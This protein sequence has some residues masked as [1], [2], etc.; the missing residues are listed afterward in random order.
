MKLF[1]CSLVALCLASPFALA[2]DA[3]QRAQLNGAS[4][5]FADL[6]D[7][8]LNPSKYH[9]QRS[10]SDIQISCKDSQLKWVLD[11]DLQMKMAD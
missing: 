1:S 10:P 7:A 9:N 11:S 2:N 3:G 6:R 8:C 5:S 4:L